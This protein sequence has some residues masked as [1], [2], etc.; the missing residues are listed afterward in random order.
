MKIGLSNHQSVCL[1]VC[2]CVRERERE[3]DSLIPWN[4]FLKCCSYGTKNYCIEVPLNG[5]TFVPN[6]MI[7]QAAQKLL[8]GDTQT[9]RQADK[10]TDRLVIL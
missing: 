1:Y 2:V 4:C 9:G 3:R 8:V 5:I 10:Q 6:I 7:Y